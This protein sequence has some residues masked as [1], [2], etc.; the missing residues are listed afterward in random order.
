[1]IWSDLLASQ[2]RHAFAKKNKKN[3]KLLRPSV[4]IMFRMRGE[5]TKQNKTREKKNEQNKSAA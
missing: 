2:C 5:K 1:M 3:K 4:V